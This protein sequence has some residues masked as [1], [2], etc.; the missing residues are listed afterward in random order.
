MKA[1]AAL[2]RLRRLGMAAAAGAFGAVVL[3]DHALEEARRIGLDEADVIHALATASKCAWQPV[4]GTWKVKGV[5]R[6]GMTVV[7]AVD[8]QAAAIVVTAFD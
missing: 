7:L 2:A 4:H 6:F 5:D 1:K 8:L 3:T